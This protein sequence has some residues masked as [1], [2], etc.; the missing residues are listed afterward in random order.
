MASKKPKAP[1]SRYR[2]IPLPPP[3][4]SFTSPGRHRFQVGQGKRTE[5][6]PGDPHWREEWP[7]LYEGKRAGSLTRST[8]FGQNKPRWDAYARELHRDR[9][10][11]SPT[12]SGLHF[13]M[14][15]F[16]TVNEATAAFESMADRI[17][18]YERE[19]VQYRRDRAKRNKQLPK[20]TC[21][22]LELPPY[23]YGPR[24]PDPPGTVRVVARFETDDDIEF[25]VKQSRKGKDWWIYAGQLGRRK[26]N[27]LHTTDPKKAAHWIEAVGSGRVRVGS[28]G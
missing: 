15:P 21:P 19:R 5:S 13:D 9:A 28:R 25:E 7:V 17:F 16:E 4:E 27:T 26:S 6:Y 12:R 18:E 14:G 10:A 2:E 20:S 1:V 11:S 8:P 23:M 3:L 22:V 24:Q